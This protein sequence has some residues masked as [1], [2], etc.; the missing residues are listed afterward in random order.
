MTRLNLHL[1]WICIAAL[2]FQVIVSTGLCKVSSGHSQTA[3]LGT[4][5]HSGRDGSADHDVHERKET[6]N[7]IDTAGK[8]QSLPGL[9]DERLNSNTQADSHHCCVVD[10]SLTR[11]PPI[12][13]YRQVVPHQALFSFYSFA[14]KPQH[15]PPIA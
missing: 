1:I 3:S 12:D 5:C 6:S 14:Q 2:C 8:V 10:L 15:R 9:D 11:I 4:L 7:W 13:D